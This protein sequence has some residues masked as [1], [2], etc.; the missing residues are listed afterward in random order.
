MSNLLEGN[1]KSWI[2]RVINFVCNC[3]FVSKS[4]IRRVINFVCNCHF[5]SKLCWCIYLLFCFLAGQYINFKTTKRWYQLF[6]FFGYVWFVVQLFV[7]LSYV[8]AVGTIEGLRIL[9]GLRIYNYSYFINIT[10]NNTFNETIECLLPDEH[11]KFSTAVT[12]SSIAAFLSY[13]LMTMLVLIPV[14]ISRCCRDEFCSSGCCP[15]QCC[16]S[17]IACIRCKEALRHDSLSLYEDEDES[18]KMDT[19]QK[20][21]FFINYLIVLLFFTVSFSFSIVYAVSDTTYDRGYGYGYCR[22]DS[23]YLAMIVLQLISQ[24]C[25]IQSCFIFSKIVYVIS[26]KLVRL[27]T[28][29][30]QVYRNDR[31]CY[32]RLLKV[33]QDFIDQVKYIL[34][35]LGIW[36]IFHWTLYALTTVLLSALLLKLSSMFLNMTSCQRIN[37]CQLPT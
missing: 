8:G 35:L 20:I 31:E 30:K 12:V 10:V 22:Y 23:L 33:D 13:V 27:D 7:C 24:F 16:C 15:D 28:K 34:H 21:Y 25:A 26:N 6:S 2:T 1:E 5:V 36:F 37:Y 29:M 19:E 4:W 32:K 3:Q 9:E 11:W 18:S 17:I 14:D